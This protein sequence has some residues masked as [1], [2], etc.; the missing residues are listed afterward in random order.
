VFG[1][2][3]VL[4]LSG[5][6][7]KLMLRFSFISSYMYLSLSLCIAF[8]VGGAPRVRAALAGEEDLV[9]GSCEGGARSDMSDSRG[10]LPTISSPFFY[11]LFSSFSVVFLWR[12][13]EAKSDER[14]SL[15][16]GLEVGFGVQREGA[17]E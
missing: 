2:V 12:G 1:F 16:F 14:L 9:L 3:F 8:P 13:G 15:G 5:R 17:Q 6:R 11:Y 7:G 10:C 4:G